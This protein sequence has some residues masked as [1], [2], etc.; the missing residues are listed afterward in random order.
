MR[1]PDT[2]RKGEEMYALYKYTMINLIIIHKNRSLFYSFSA[3]YYTLHAYRLTVRVHER[4]WYLGRVNWNF[5]FSV[6]YTKCN[7]DSHSLLYK[8][9]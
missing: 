8:M 4:L 5:N 7:N 9:Q 6:Y 3:K 2:R 1:V